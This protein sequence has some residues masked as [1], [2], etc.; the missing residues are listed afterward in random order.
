MET[1]HN[2][3]FSL[4]FE[5]YFPQIK[6]LIEETEQFYNKQ[7]EKLESSELLGYEKPELK[8]ARK[9]G[10]LSLNLKDVN[11]ILPRIYLQKEDKQAN[12]YFYLITNPYNDVLYIGTR[13]ECEN[14]LSMSVS[15]LTGG[16]LPPTE[17]KEAYNLYLGLMSAI[18]YY[19]FCI[20]YDVDTCYKDVILKDQYGEDKNYIVKKVLPTAIYKQLIEAE[21]ENNFNQL[22]ILNQ[23]NGNTA[24]QDNINKI[25][26]AV[27]LFK[28]MLKYDL[29]PTLNIVKKNNTT[30][31]KE[32]FFK[33]TGGEKWYLRDFDYLP[34]RVSDRGAWACDKG[35]LECFKQGNFKWFNTLNECKEA[36]VNVRKMLGISNPDSTQNTWSNITSQEDEVKNNNNKIE[37]RFD[38]QF[39]IPY[40]LTF[41]IT[42]K[43]QSRFM[44]KNDE[45]VKT[46]IKP[47][48]K[49]MQR[50]ND[51]EIT[52]DYKMFLKL[53][54]S[55]D[56]VEQWEKWEKYHRTTIFEA[57]IRQLYSD[58]DITFEYT[59]PKEEN[60][61]I[62]QQI[63]IKSINDISSFSKINE[64]I[65]FLCSFLK[66]KMCKFDII[67]YLHKGTDEETENANKLDFT[68]KIIKNNTP[69]LNL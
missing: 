17:T 50:L 35:V 51:G 65:H 10:T 3:G 38:Q 27:S 22:P 12:P 25:W 37:I 23:R 11:E 1:N 67:Y 49:L 33:E 18:K 39:D 2:S 16:F 62:K 69:Y 26:E 42:E 53:T 36:S 41:D 19:Q 55:E 44:F 28:G 5:A 21:K 8:Q 52:Q 7:F 20:V 32:W 68:D 46:L 40:I 54:N 13:L 4:T 24:Q 30:N 14:I 57:Q 58:K 31:F 45:E 64:I 34:E 6:M 48:Q 15:A 66:I 61:L 47:A 59:D 9:I 29:I 60:N 63:K 43:S 56:S